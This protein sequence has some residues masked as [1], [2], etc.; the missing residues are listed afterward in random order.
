MYSHQS[1]G[2]AEEIEDQLVGEPLAEDQLVVELLVEDQLVGEPLAED[3]SV[4]E[5]LVE[6]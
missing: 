1:V 2:S 4:V 5:L 3:Q 6:D